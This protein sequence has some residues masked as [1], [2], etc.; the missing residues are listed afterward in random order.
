MLPVIG[1]VDQ[2]AIWPDRH[3]PAIIIGRVSEI[4]FT[5]EIDFQPDNRSSIEDKGR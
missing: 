2:F 1:L 4:H 3:I 5:V